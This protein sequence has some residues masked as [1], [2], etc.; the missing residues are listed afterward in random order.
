M[1]RSEVEKCQKNLIC[2]NDISI[3]YTENEGLSFVRSFHRD[4]GKYSL[5]KYTK[6]LA[7]L[8]IR[9]KS[10]L[11]IIDFDTNKLPGNYYIYNAYTSKL[12]VFEN[13]KKSDEPKYIT[14]QVT[15]KKFGESMMVSYETE[16]WGKNLLSL[17]N[18]KKSREEQYMDDL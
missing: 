5:K 16:N 18:E 15:N 2:P 4:F 17:I 7:K 1:T 11:N 14:L 6:L 13:N 12:H 10:V 3:Y 9:Y 8:N